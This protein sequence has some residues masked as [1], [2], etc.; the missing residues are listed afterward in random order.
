[1]CYDLVCSALLGCVVNDSNA[2]LGNHCFGITL[3]AS[4]VICL[5]EIH[6][7]NSLSTPV[8]WT[9]GARLGSAIS[10]SRETL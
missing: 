1:M 8:K 5:G 2:A 6:S 3:V 4:L 9:T 7:L 10:V